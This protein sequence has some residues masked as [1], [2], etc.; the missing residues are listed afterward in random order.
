MVEEQLLRRG[1]DDPRVLDAFRTVPRDHFVEAGDGRRAFAD[2]PLRI[3]C[4]QTISQPYVVAVTVDA[5]RIGP[6]HRVLDVGTGSGYAAAILGHLAGEVHSIERHADLATTAA[7]RLAALGMD[8]VHV[9]LGDGSVGLP[10]HAPFDAIAVAAAAPAVPPAL[11]QQL[12]D[13]GRLVLPVGGRTRQDLVLVR[14]DAIGDTDVGGVRV[15]RRTLLGVRF[16][17]LVGEQGQ[18][19]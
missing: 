13:G 6:D 8:H 17:P 12:T 5:L 14:R 10:D 3:G 4:G 1:I 9:H 11:V 7:S 2:R 15:T 16:V 19:G 18:P